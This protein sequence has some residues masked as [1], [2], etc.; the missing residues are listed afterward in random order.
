MNSEDREHPEYLTKIYPVKTMQECDRR[1]VEEFSIPARVLMENAGTAAAQ[2]AKRLANRE[3]TNLICCGLGNNG[4]DGL[5]TARHL[6]SDDY[7]VS[8]ILAGPPEKLKGE[9]LANF[10][11]LQKCGVVPSN[12]EDALS[13]WEAPDSPRRPPGLI[14]DALFGTGLSRPPEGLYAQLIRM[15]NRISSPV[16]SLDI[17]SG[18]LGDTGQLAGTEAVQAEETVIFGGMKPGNIL[19]P[20]RAHGG[21]QS[22]APISFPPAL[23]ASAG[24]GMEINPPGKPPARSPEGHKGS[25]GSVLII[26]GSRFYRGAPLLTARAAMVSGAGSAIL[27]VPEGLVPGLAA[28]APEVIF[29][30]QPETKDGSLDSQ[31]VKALLKTASQSHAVV[32]GPG[33]SLQAETRKAVRALLP[34]IEAPL[35]VDADALTILAGD[36]SLTSRRSV[37]AVLTPHPGEAARLLQ[38]SSAEIQQDRI[39]AARKIAATYKAHVILK[40]AGTV[41]ASRDRRSLRINPTGNSGMGTAGAGDVLA[42]ILGSLAA[43]PPAAPYQ[44]FCRAVYIHGLSG[45]LAAEK[46]GKAAVTASQL[47][48]FLPPAQELSLRDPEYTAEIFPKRL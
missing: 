11:S 37:P 27:A 24:T 46:V 36:P 26:A 18:I 34:A 21:R 33:L 31:G 6:L 44:A 43:H 35:I 10:E 30:P 25:F 28:A 22:I 39:A 16:L 47:I 7:P 20:G 13:Q 38:T 41:I 40:G 32:L 45:D 1:A 12:P 19:F 3:K 42:G 9:S 4:G 17:P 14:I 23:R 48:Q 5:V 29:S 8:V 15:M 2:R